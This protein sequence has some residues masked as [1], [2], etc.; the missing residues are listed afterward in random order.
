[1]NRQS[2]TGAII[3]KLNNQNI[4]KK[5]ILVM[6]NGFDL[7]H[8]LPTNYKDFIDILNR[9]IELDQDGKR[10]ASWLTFLLCKESPLYDKNTSI[11]ACFDTYQKQIANTELDVNNINTMINIA[12]D[13]IWFNYFKICMQ[14]DIKWID[15][16]KEIRYVIE[17]FELFFNQIMEYYDELVTEED[18]VLVIQKFHLKL[19]VQYVIDLFDFFKDKTFEEDD[20]KIAIKNEYTIKKNTRNETVLMGIDEN[21]IMNTLADQLDYF[22]E[23]FEIYIVEIINKITID[24]TM[25]NSMIFDKI[26]AVI[27]FNYTDTYKNIYD[28]NIADECIEFIHG[29]AGSKNIVFGINSDS[30][31]K[32]ENLNENYIKFKKEYRRLR[33]GNLLNYKRLLNDDRAINFIFFGHSLDETDGDILKELITWDC[34][35]CIIYYLDDKARDSYLINLYKFFGIDK[36]KE[37]VAENK[38]EFRLILDYE[39]NGLKI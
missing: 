7:Y 6:G 25:M 38:L 15:F 17:R 20:L 39:S 23:L 32:L 1:M 22:S 10:K 24:K 19:D 8:K 34:A 13:N 26:D 28:N 30:H 14:N 11:K 2:V 5:N 31:D 36:I 37:L 12:K 29:K 16:E 3:D 27:S 18:G 9:L 35:H 4:L 33:N 21:K